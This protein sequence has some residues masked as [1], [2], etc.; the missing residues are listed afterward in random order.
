MIRFNFVGNPKLKIKKSNIDKILRLTERN[1]KI[2]KNYGISIVLVD[3]KTIKDLN[4]RYRRKNKVTDILTFCYKE[5][6]INENK[7]SF[8]NFTDKDYLGDIIISHERLKKQAREYKRTSEQ[9]FCSLLVHGLLHLF[10]YDHHRKKDRERM[11]KMENLI[12]N[13]SIWLDKAKG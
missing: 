9:E 4:I 7:K 13:G 2:K 11:E 10:G 8:L 12:L 1:L 6:K 3:N 5:K